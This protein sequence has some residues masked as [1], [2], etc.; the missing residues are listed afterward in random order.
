MDF[1]CPGPVSV[2]WRLRPGRPSGPSSRAGF[3]LLPRPLG[4][5][6]VSDEPGDLSCLQGGNRSPRPRFAKGI[7]L[8]SVGEGAPGGGAAELR[9]S[10]GG[11]GSGA[12]RPRRAPSAG[13]VGPG[14][15]R[16]RVSLLRCTLGNV[17]WLVLPG[18]IRSLC[19]GDPRLGSFSV[20]D[21]GTSCPPSYRGRLLPVVVGRGC[22][23]APLP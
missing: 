16:V 20:A 14:M 18:A 1:D 15:A 7:L 8:A 19:A 10:G 22:M 4:W 2:F 3:P 17:V 13:P 23:L 6:R 11:A 5:S 21:T 9:A 12:S